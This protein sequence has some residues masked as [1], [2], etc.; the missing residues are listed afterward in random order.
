[1][2]RRG[3]SGRQLVGLAALWLAACAHS[4]SFYGD[5]YPSAHQYQSLFAGP[6]FDAF[7]DPYNAF[8]APVCGTTYFY[9]PVYGPAYGP[10]HYPGRPPWHPWPGA[11]GWPPPKPP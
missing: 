11:G 8:C 3:D 4:P 1:M 7:Y 2:L 10:G 6:Y 9:Y 5:V